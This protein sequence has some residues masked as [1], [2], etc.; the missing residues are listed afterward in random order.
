MAS[1][2]R[3]PQELRDRIFDFLLEKVLVIVMNGSCPCQRALFVE[4]SPF[5]ILHETDRNGNGS[6]ITYK[7]HYFVCSTVPKACK[8]LRADT[9]SA[10]KRLKS[11][12]VC[13]TTSP[14]TALEFINCCPR[15]LRSSITDLI[16]ADDCSCH[17]ALDDPLISLPERANEK[18]WTTSEVAQRLCGRYTDRLSSLKNVALLVP[19]S[20]VMVSQ[21]LRR[22]YQKFFDALEDG[23]LKEISVILG[24]QR[25]SQYRP[26]LEYEQTWLLGRPRRRLADE[27][28]HRDYQIREIARL[29]AKNEWL[30]I[31][32]ERWQDSQGNYRSIPGVQFVFRMQKR[33][34]L[35]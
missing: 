13:L 7:V 12:Q 1:I 22:L 33:M 9:I 21:N 20:M 10:V 29:R 19:T 31:L 8:Q 14:T 32:T 18:L 25:T 4:G 17:Y 24:H 15:G 28:S 26:D 2:L 30:D 23:R 35:E 34:P 27:G 11:G 16:L 3:L 6:F 5:S